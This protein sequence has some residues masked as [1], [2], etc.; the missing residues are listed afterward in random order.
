MMG[1]AMQLSLLLDCGTGTNF[2]TD[3]GM[4]RQMA[5]FDFGCFYPSQGIVGNQTSSSGDASCDFGGVVGGLSSIDAVSTIAGVSYFIRVSSHFSGQTGNF[6]LELIDLA[7]AP[8]TLVG[9]WASTWE[10]GNTIS[11]E[12]SSE[13]NV[14][15]HVIERSSTG[16]GDWQEVGKLVSESAARNGAFYELVDDEPF[17]NTYYRLR[18]V[19]YDGSEQFSDVVSVKRE[20]PEFDI[21]KVYPNPIMDGDVTIQIDSDRNEDINIRV[22]DV[23]GK[24][25]EAFEYA[26]RDGLN[27]I[28]INVS[29]WRSGVYF[30]Q[31]QSRQGYSTRKIFKQE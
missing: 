9:F 25:V 29:D 19:D 7:P 3:L 11:W 26:I 24:N 31:F 15:W 4:L 8:V 21:T 20:R 6:D 22:V 12:T 16:Y 30:V 2:D 5:E 17:N 13:E 14:L 28:R 27:Q 10:K 18:T 1:C 23:T